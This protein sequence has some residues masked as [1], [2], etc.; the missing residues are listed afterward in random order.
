MRFEGRLVR[1]GKNFQRGFCWVYCNNSHEGE[2]QELAKMKDVVSEM[3][4]FQ[5]GGEQNW[6][7][8]AKSPLKYFLWMG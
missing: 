1:R 2:M 5:Y 6:P 3:H 4:C 7:E 8:A